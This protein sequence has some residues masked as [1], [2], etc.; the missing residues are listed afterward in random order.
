[1]IPDKLKNKEYRFIKIV[2]DT[3]KA[4]EKDWQTSYN[5]KYNEKE[6]EDYLKESNAYGILCRYG[7]LA[8][9]DCDDDKVAS[10]IAFKLPRTFTVTTG[11][12]GHHFYFKI[13]D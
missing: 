3:K 2:N 5:Y 11:S 6:F 1:M 10:D 13:P 8:V 9:I 12:G 4:L 7:N